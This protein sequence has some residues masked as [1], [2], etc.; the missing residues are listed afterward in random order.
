[1]M[2]AIPT[3]SRE[4]NPFQEKS[5]SSSELVSVWLEGLKKGE[6]EAAA[7]LWEHY[8]RRLVSL[9]R[10]RLRSLKRRAAADEEDV[11]LSAFH[12]FCQAARKD[13]YA[14][15]H[16]RNDLWRVL[17]VFTANKAKTLLDRERAG[18]RGGGRVR[19]ESALEGAD[20]SSGSP[21]L[22]GMVGREPEASL[23]AEMEEKF[24]RFLAR[25]TDDEAEVARL[26]LE[27]YRTEEIAEQVGLSPATVRRRLVFIRDVL[28]E[29][30]GESEETS[31]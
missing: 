25:L 7:R 20:G 2:R 11:A 18:R 12:D 14:D 9:A 6:E 16:G 28:A 31:R 26:K 23:S 1:M 15:L 19:G 17:V 10:A 30:F 24:Q 21:G 13:R 4:S 29:E 27:G 8:F 5:M 22:E 3:K